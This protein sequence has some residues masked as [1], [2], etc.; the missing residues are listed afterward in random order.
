MS[1]D[2]KMCPFCGERPEIEVLK[3]LYKV[4]CIALCPIQP[5]TAWIEDKAFVIE[6]WNTR[7]EGK[8]DE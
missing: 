3:G 1:E 5:E 8:E 4:S 2:M 7:R 6:V